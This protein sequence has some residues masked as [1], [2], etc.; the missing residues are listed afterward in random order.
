VA[1]KKKRK[2]KLI[3]FMSCKCK[4]TVGNSQV[5]IDSFSY[6]TIAELYRKHVHTFPILF[7]CI[8]VCS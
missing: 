1:V 7:I 8:A 2:I 6:I 3:A 5:T 4:E